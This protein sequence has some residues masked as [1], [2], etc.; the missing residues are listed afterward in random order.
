MWKVRSYIQHCCLQS[1]RDWTTICNPAKSTCFL[2]VMHNQHI[3]I[4]DALKLTSSYFVP[5][6]TVVLHGLCYLQ[7][8][9]HQEQRTN[10]RRTTAGTELC[11]LSLINNGVQSYAE[12]AAKLLKSISMVCVV[13]PLSRQIPWESHSSDGGTRLWLFA[14]DPHRT[15]HGS[16]AYLCTSSFLIPWYTEPLNH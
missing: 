5:N 12:A 10:V 8:C 9:N 13:W 3:M 15:A 6:G 1:S 16:S 14:R 2:Q 11:T 7:I 4:T